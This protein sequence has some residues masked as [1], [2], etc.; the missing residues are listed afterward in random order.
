MAVNRTSPSGSKIIDIPANA[1]TI[2]A[3][4]ETGGGNATVA[5][6]A[7]STAVGG[8][9]FDYIATSTPGS[10]TGTGTTSPISVS[11]LTIGT[12][13]TFTVA[14]RNASGTSPLSSA[15]N[16]IVPTIATSFE[17]IATVSVGSGGAASISFT[18]IPS[19]YTHLQLRGITRGGNETGVFAAFNGTGGNGHAWFGRGN[20]SSVGAFRETAGIPFSATPATGNAT[21]NTATFVADILD[22]ANTNKFKTTRSLIGL[23]VTST[24]NT[25]VFMESGL[26]QSTSAISSIT[27]TLGSGNFAQFTHIAL[28]GIKGV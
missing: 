10:I 3:A 12:S 17:S 15:S 23:E 2:G 26:W 25:Y 21:E 19:T 24:G 27:L 13:Y 6:T 16:S 11:G 9:V 1:P 20:G 7:A 28:Y 22:Y 5:F 14:S 4:T 18:S 8:P